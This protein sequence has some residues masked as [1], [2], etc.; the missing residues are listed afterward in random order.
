MCCNQAPEVDSVVLVILASM[1]RE[2]RRA[3]GV[4]EIA[5]GAQFEDP[6]PLSIPLLY[7]DKEPRLACTEEVG[8]L[9]KVARLGTSPTGPDLVELVDRVGRIWWRR[10][11]FFHPESRAY[12]M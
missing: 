12:G 10:R 2:G 8:A 9:E 3:H 1:S 4:W 11:G 5:D 6:P 7:L